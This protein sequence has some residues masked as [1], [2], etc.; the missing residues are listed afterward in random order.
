LGAPDFFD[1]LGEG[2]MS[3]YCPKQRIQWY[4]SNE[5]SKE[6][7]KT[8]MKGRGEGGRGRKEGCTESVHVC[9]VV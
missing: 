6:E 3:D 1:I 8:W 4:V 2:G 7:Y 9:V 5:V